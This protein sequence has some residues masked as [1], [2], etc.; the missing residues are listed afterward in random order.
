MLIFN[1]SYFD[2]ESLQDELVYIAGAISPAQMCVLSAG[3]QIQGMKLRDMFLE[4]R[5]PSMLYRPQ[6]CQPREGSQTWLVIILLAA[7]PLS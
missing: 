2:F 6:K 3:L 5:I 1:L 7:S 4:L